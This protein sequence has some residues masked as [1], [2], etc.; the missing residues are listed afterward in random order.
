MTERAGG[1]CALGG[2]DTESGGGGVLVSGG[3]LGGR[4]ARGAAGDA[5]GSG[6]SK[7][8]RSAGS[9][10]ATTQASRASPSGVFPEGGPFAAA[11]VGLMDSPLEVPSSRPLPCRTP[12]AAN[13]PGIAREPA[14][15]RRA[16]RPNPSEA[17]EA[18]AE[19][20]T[21]AWDGVVPPLLP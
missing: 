1:G 10:P 2:R 6:I 19:A 20:A 16:L 12:V 15:E 11:A 7:L 21:P 14:S 5:V 17:A 9:A 3:T 13:S 18:A 4:R 8:P